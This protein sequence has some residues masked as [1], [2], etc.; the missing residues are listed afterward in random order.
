M[1]ER[2]E[3]PTWTEEFHHHMHYVTPRVNIGRE[4][5]TPYYAALQTLLENVTRQAHNE[6]EHV[7]MQT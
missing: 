2:Q 3:Y 5:P 7:M 1:G 6:K 4:Y